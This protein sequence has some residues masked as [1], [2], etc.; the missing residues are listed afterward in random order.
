MPRNGAVTL[1]DIAGKVAMLEAA[2]S[3]CER[4][5][6]YRVARL[7]AEHGPDMSLPE[8]RFIIAADCPRMETI[9]IQ[10]TSSGCRAPVPGVSG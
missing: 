10:S 2:C 6:R 4:R 7:I 9:D 8:L 1:G 3:R 5:G